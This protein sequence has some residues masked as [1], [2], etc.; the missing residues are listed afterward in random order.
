MVV[1]ISFSNYS[2]LIEVI[3]ILKK[4][5]TITLSHYKIL[6]TYNYISHRYH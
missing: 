1:N 5:K 2:S 3:R 4:K 6:I